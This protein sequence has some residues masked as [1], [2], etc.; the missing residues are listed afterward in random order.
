[1]NILPPKF[2]LILLSILVSIT[3]YLPAQNTESNCGTTTTSESLEYFKSLKPQIEKFEQEFMLRKTNTSKGHS[4]RVINSIPIKAHIIRH[5]DG[6]G[7]L[8][9]SKLNTAIANLNAIYADAYMEFFLCD[10]IN[11]INEDALCDFKKGDEKILIETNNVNGLINIYFADYIENTSEE[12]ICGY[13]DNAG[14]NDI[15]VMKTDCATNGSSLAHE[16]GH[17]FSLIHTHG[18]DNTKT[19]ELVDGSNCDTDGDGICDTP[20]DPILTNTNV[21]NYCKYTGHETDAN[22]D[23]YAPD[24]NNIMSYSRKGCRNRFTPQQLARMYAFYQTAKSYLAC[25]SFNA[26][27]SAD[28]SQTCEESLTVNFANNCSGITQWQW[29]IDSDGIV[30]YTTENP[31]HTYS[32]GNYDVTLIVSNKSK[33]VTK[34]FANFIKVGTQTDF[35]NEEFENII[36]IGESDWTANDLSGNGYNWLLKKGGTDTEKTGPLLKNADNKVNTYIYAEATGAQPNDVTELI[37]PC[38]YIEHQN[39]AIEFAYHMFGSGIGELHVDIETD[40]GYIYDAIEPFYG[41]QQYHQS[42]NFLTQ[43]ID[44]SSYV[45]QTINIHFRA[46]RGSNW[47]GDIALDNIFIKTIS[48]PISDEPV[49]VYPNPIKGDVVYV[50]GNNF[51]ALLT[52]YHISNLEG[53]IFTSGTLSGANQP[54]NVGGLSSGMYLLTIRNKE[55]TITKKIIK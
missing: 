18:P 55:T 15:I 42:D 38:I 34:T 46:V 24:T 10:G 11:Y 20:A 1:M 19:T 12:G 22:G 9:I 16:M 5:S 51:K 25:P 31:T 29:D 8:S 21:N 40:Y 39:S 50:K 27:F 17:F 47:D 6:S 48:V 13:S 30:D 53:Q 36:M 14:R 43:D 3:F 23:K 49:K 52:T 2:H 35:L 45:N 4:S 33:T 32:T 41:S 7:G 54:I 37:S 26:N 28:I 44:L